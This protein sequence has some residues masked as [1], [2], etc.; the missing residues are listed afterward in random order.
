MM[1]FSSQ[2][3]P[4]FVR[5]NNFPYITGQYKVLP[6]HAFFNPEFFYLNRNFW[7]EQGIYKPYKRQQ[8]LRREEEEKEKRKTT[9][10]HMVEPIPRVLVR[11]FT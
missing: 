9:Y 1:Y 10:N 11:L 7:R 5:G 2:E 8:K 3:M 4:T 6:T